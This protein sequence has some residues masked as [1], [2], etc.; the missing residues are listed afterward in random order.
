M[1]NKTNIPKIIHYMW[2]GSKTPDDVKKNIETWK[3][4]CPDY[5]F[6]E[7]NEKNFDMNLCPFVKGAYENKK[8][9]FVSDYVRIWAIKKYGGIWLD[10]DVELIKSLDTFL[11]CK[12]FIGF[13]N[14]ANL[15]ASTFGFPKND[16]TVSMLLD[17]YNKRQFD[18]NKNAV[19]P[20]S[21][22]FTVIFHKLYGLKYKNKN[23]VLSN[24]I[25]VFTS[26]YFIAKDYTTRKVTI[27]KNTCAIHKY[28]A[29]WFNGFAKF[30]AK[31]L[32]VVR[33]IVGKKIFGFF[34]KI[35][36]KS[37]EGRILKEFKK[38]TEQKNNT[39]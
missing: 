15:E 33:Y 4:F 17:F 10:T 30:L 21:I 11:N 24:G 37:I 31:V 22:M 25:N 14:E 34:T 32:K 3:K 2:I 36:I 38:V 26:D 23:Q 5:T 39:K 35:Y 20:N 19:T 1:K 13:E 28:A 16:P 9:A 12:A 6:M 29:T 7:W 18:T 8:Y 27:T